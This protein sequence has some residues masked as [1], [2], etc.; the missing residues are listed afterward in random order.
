MELTKTDIE[1]PAQI[2]PAKVVD[3]LFLS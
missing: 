3:L 1:Y 2:D